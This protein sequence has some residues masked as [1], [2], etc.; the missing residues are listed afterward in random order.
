MGIAFQLMFLV[1][2]YKGRKNGEEAKAMESF[3]NIYIERIS[4]SLASSE[5][6]LKIW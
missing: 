1:P 4:I 5:H 3:I 6:A 2:K